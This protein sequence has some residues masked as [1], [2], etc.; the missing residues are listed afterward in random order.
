M[1]KRDKLPDGARA[2]LDSKMEKRT[3]AKIRIRKL[4]KKRQKEHQKKIKA[5]RKKTNKKKLRKQRKREAQL[6]EG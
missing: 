2:V 3:G 6:L 1:K 4:R 5:K